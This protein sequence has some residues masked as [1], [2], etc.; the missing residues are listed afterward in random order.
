MILCVSPMLD[1]FFFFNI[2]QNLRGPGVK[3]TLRDSI[4]LQPRYFFF[5]FYFLWTDY[6]WCVDFIETVFAKGDP[7]IAALF[8][9]LL[10]DDALKLI[11]EQLRSNNDG[12]KELLLKVIIWLSCR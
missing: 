2:L 6:L 7:R 9:H 5:I 12:P 10:V 4:D 3:S 1:M 8:D 11:G